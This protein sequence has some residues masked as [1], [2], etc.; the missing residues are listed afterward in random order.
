MLRR[1]LYTGLGEKRCRDEAW[2]EHQDAF[3]E[4]LANLNAQATPSSVSKCPDE[5]GV[6][7]QTTKALLETASE[8]KRLV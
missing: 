1:F 7:P 2:I 8:S 6:T 5:V 4:I 3:D